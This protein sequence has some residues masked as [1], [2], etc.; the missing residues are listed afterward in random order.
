MTSSKLPINGA[1][2]VAVALSTSSLWADASDRL[3]VHGFVSQAALYSEGNNF[4][5][6]SRNGSTEFMEAGLNGQY[7]FNPRAFLSAQITTRDAGA[8]DNGEVELDYLFGDIKAFE[9]DGSGMGFRVGRVRNIYGF[10]NK[11]RDVAFTRSTI[12]MPQA[13]YFEGNGLREILFA[14]DGAQLYSYW[15]AAGN[16]TSFSMTYGINREVKDKVTRN[17]FGP[18]SSAITDATLESPIFAQIQHSRDGGVRRFALSVLDLSLHIDTALPQTPNIDLVANGF[19]ASGQLNLQHWSFT[20][21]TAYTDVKFRGTQTD[22]DTSIAAAYLQAQYRFNPQ[23]SI[24]SRYEY[25]NIKSDDDHD[26]SGHWVL[27]SQWSP[28]RN[29]L[30]SADYYY[31]RG[32]NGIPLGDNKGRELDSRTHVFAIMASYRF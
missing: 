19:A 27:G 24:L 23:V 4:Y 30:I 26:S 14:S 32:T 7:S 11:T 25:S 21:E 16:S 5:G 1:F 29:W 12:L 13:I 18:A 2:A 31:M 6:D 8:T 15:D 3:H 28:S 20:A 22:D 10:Y 9:T 17:L